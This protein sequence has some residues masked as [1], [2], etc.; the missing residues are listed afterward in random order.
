MEA[1]KFNITIESDTIKIPALSKFIGKRMEI[2][3]IE[4]LPEKNI[5][6]KDKKLK[7]LKGKINLDEDSILSLRNK[8]LI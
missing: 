3:L 7:N 4:D 1:L 2:I 6:E 5:K 8:S